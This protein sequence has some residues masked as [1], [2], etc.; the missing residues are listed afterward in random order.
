MAETPRTIVRL[1]MRSTKVLMVISGTL[2]TS[3]G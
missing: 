1:D 2:R 3:W